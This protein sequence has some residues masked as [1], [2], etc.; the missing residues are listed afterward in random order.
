[1][2]D[3]KLFP[4]EMDLS[5]SAF[6]YKKEDFSVSCIKFFL[7]T[8]QT[9]NVTFFNFPKLSV[10][11][12][13]RRRRVAH[14]MRRR[15]RR[16]FQTF[17]TQRTHLLRVY[18]EGRRWRLWWPNKRSSQSRRIETRRTISWTCSYWRWREDCKRPDRL[19]VEK[20]FAKIASSKCSLNF[21]IAL[22]PSSARR[23]VNR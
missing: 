9:R 8:F 22:H 6:Q 13:K 23:F 12:R 10:H 5:A 14:R 21:M 16:V 7:F 1:M 2:T 11:R 3:Q 19:L 17:S 15:G 4:I 20:K 18:S